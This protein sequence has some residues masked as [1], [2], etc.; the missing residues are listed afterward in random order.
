[1]ILKCKRKSTKCCTTNSWKIFFQKSRKYDARTPC[2]AT[3]KCIRFGAGGRG[4]QA[5]YNGEKLKVKIKDNKILH[6]ND[7]ENENRN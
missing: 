3:R 1:M 6:L 4:C 7:V 5:A 2:W